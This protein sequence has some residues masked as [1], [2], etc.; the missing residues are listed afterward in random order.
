MMDSK[1]SNDGD[2]EDDD[3]ES[4]GCGDRLSDSVV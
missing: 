2:R 3:D 1:K 4:R